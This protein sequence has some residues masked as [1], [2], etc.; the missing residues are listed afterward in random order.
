[1]RGRS[2]YS[3]S[4]TAL[5]FRR[6]TPR[7]GTAQSRAS[8]A[9]P[10]EGLAG[11]PGAVSIRRRLR[12]AAGSTIGCPLRRADLLA[13]V[14]DQPRVAGPQQQPAKLRRLPRPAGAGDARPGVQ[15][16]SDRVQRLPGEHPIR[17][18]R[19]R[20][21]PPPV[22]RSRRR[23]HTRTAAGPPDSGQRRRPAASAASAFRSCAPPRSERPR[24]ASGPPSARTAWPSRA[25]RP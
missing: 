14:L 6:R 24:R 10:R 8:A 12:Q 4:P 7:T 25:D 18:R 2:R 17:R 19:R 16:P 21:R 13:V 1:M 9:P 3:H 22:A 5:L 11:G 23:S 15:V 20:S